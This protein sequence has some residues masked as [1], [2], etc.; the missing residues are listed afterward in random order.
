MSLPLRSLL[1]E[2]RVSDA[3]LVANELREAGFELEWKRIETEPDFRAEITAGW[4][5]I[6]ADYSLP[7]FDALKALRIVREAKCDVPLIIV[8]GTIADEAAVVV[9]KEG[10]ADYLL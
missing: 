1:L 8:S 5:I 7:Q 2:D 6:L 3:K 4:D 9:M 10:A